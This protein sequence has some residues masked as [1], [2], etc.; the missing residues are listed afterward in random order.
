MGVQISA[1]ARLATSIAAIPRCELLPTLVKYPPAITAPALTAR[2]S[3]SLKFAG[4]P[5]NRGIPRGNRASAGIG[6]RQQTA[7]HAPGGAEGAA[8]VDR[9]G[10]HQQSFDTAAGAGIP[11][12]RN[13]GGQIERGDADTLH[14]ADP[15]EVPP[16]WSTEPDAAS[17]YTVLLGF[18][19]HAS[20]LPLL[21]LIAARFD[22]GAPPALKNAPP[23]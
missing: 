4:L 11:G 6:G 21:R 15:E 3:T 5:Q 8:D 22:R 13:A 12:G 20:A 2:A 14:R 10:R 17:A 16:T 23:T 9:P 19:V 18:G 1:P 7:R